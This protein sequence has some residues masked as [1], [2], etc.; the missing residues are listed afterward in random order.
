MR[1]KYTLQTAR[2][3]VCS[4][5][6]RKYHLARHMTSKGHIARMNG[7]YVTMPSDEAFTVFLRSLTG[8]SFRGY[9][10]QRYGYYRAQVLGF[11][12]TTRA[13]VRRDWSLQA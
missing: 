10:A 5:T 4:V 11:V 13:P 6:V 1:K 3:E 7:G 8:S 12:G 2:C 9:E